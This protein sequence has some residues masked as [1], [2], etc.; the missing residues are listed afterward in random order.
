MD[1]EISINDVSGT[2]VGAQP[3]TMTLAELEADAHGTF[4]RYRQNHSVVRHE[5]GGYFVLRFADGERLSKDPRL[6]AT[7]TAFPR[8]LG[9]EGGAIFEVFDHGMLTADGETHRR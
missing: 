5:A 3:P 2:P 1:T 4:R 7:G 9:L 6:G 8:K